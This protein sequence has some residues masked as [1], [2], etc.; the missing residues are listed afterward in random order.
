M[1]GYRHWGIEQEENRHN[2]YFWISYYD[3]TLNNPE[4]F[5]F[6][7]SN[8]GSSYYVQQYDYVAPDSEKIKEVAS[9]SEM[10]TAN[11]FMADQNAVLTEIS[12]VT[13]TPNSE[14]S[15][16]IY[17]LRSK[18]TT[19]SDGVKIQSGEG[20]TFEYGGY[21]RF[22]LKEPVTLFR[23]QAYSV[24]ISQ[25]TPSG[26][27]VFNI[28]CD[29]KHGGDAK[30]FREDDREEAP[31]ATTEEAAPEK[32]SEGTTEEAVQEKSTE[33]T[34]EESPQETGQNPPAE[35]FVDEWNEFI[36]NR[37]ESYILKDNRRILVFSNMS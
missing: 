6:D 5:V 21:H 23:G 16:E 12:T 13:T 17:L 10:K 32:T 9:D 2:G 26:K 19:P 15:Y 34:T 27:S 33:G 24:V 37:K 8:V 30:D 14:V 20:Y 3:H 4:A 29:E 35:E 36:V 11:V 1:N 22:A 25:K 18:Y 31:E 7:K 28:V